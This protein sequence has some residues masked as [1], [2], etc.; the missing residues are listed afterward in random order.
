MSPPLMGPH[1]SIVCSFSV[2]FSTP[3]R[4][5]SP[6]GLTYL[7]LFILTL[8]THKGALPFCQLC[9][10]GSLHF[11]DVWPFF[12]Y[13]Y[14][15]NG[16]IIAY[17]FNK[18]LLPLFRAIYILQIVFAEPSKVISLTVYVYSFV[19]KLTNKEDKP[20]SPLMSSESLMN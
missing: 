1:R 12:L 6:I 19:L 9:Y 20:T 8:E 13:C 15:L 14:Q 4:T 11:S 3:H 18:K 5:Q 17:L 2:T 16:Y 7:L 10:F